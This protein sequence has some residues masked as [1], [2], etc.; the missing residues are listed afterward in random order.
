MRLLSKRVKYLIYAALFAQDQQ[1]IDRPIDRQAISELS[2][3]QLSSAIITL[4]ASS[5]TENE[6]L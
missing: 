2:S 5:C 1:Q 6:N 3:T 4:S